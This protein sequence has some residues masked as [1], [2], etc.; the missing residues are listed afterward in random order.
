MFIIII[1][2]SSSSS[3]INVVLW[4]RSWA[5]VVGKGDYGDIMLA[6]IDDPA[7]GQTAVVVKSLLSSTPHH[8]AVFQHEVELFARGSHHRHVASLIGVCYSMQPPLLLTEYCE[9]VSVSK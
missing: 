1:I 3:I 8:Q 7:R 6:R 2:I 4:I 5:V 9:L